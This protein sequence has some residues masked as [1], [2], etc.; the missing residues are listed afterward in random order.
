MNPK[1]TTIILIIGTLLLSGCVSTSFSGNYVVR[2]GDILRGDLFVTS[3]SV[4][5]GENSRVTGTVILTS[6]ELHV[7]KG[8]QVGGDVVL[9][10]GALY[11]ED[12]AVVHG[13]VILSS[14]EI[15]V[16]QNPGARV[17]GRTSSSIAPFAISF[18]GKTLLLYCVLPILLLIVLIFGFGMLFGKRSKKKSQIDQGPVPAATED[19]QQKLKKLKSLLD[20]GL[21][22]ESDYEAKKSDVLS[23][24]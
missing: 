12:M 21:I 23:K 19:V 3:G 20:E 1:W 18:V 6:G 16:H 24:M 22:S 8:A 15:A 9:T 11:L 10:S 2:P 5:L 13:D 4:T 7:G 14:Q 17:E